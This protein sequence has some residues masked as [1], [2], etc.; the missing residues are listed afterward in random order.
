MRDYVFKNKKQNIFS[1]DTFPDGKHDEIENIL[2]T[3][4]II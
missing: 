2:E 4:L 3:Q 1:R